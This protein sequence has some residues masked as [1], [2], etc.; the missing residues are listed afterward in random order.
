VPEPAD[1]LP[2]HRR[3]VVPRASELVDYL[4]G[5]GRRK[6]LFGSNHPAW[7]AAGELILFFDTY[8]DKAPGVPPAGL[9][10]AEVD[11]AD[12]LFISHA[13]WDHLYGA[14]IIA[15]G[16]GATLVGNY[17]SVRLMRA[18]GVPDAQI[19]VTAGG[20]TVDCGHGV[21]VRALPSQHSGLYAAGSPD[22][23]QDCLGDLGVSAQVRQ[24]RTQA[25]FG[26]AF[27][28]SDEDRAYF[29][30]ASRS[31]SSY[32]GGQLAYL[33][34]SPAGSLLVSSSAG[35]WRSIFEPL[36]PD[37]A[38]LG[39]TGRPVLDG[40]P[41]QGSLA[42]FLAEEAALLGRP[43]VIFCHYDPLLPPLFGAT[44]ITAAETR[45]KE[46]PGQGYRRLE[47]GAPTT[48]LPMRS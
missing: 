31:T 45:L 37:V 20:D 22:S 38:I 43:E 32:D 41:Y 47:Y 3:A 2:G 28:L 36:R 48:V 8:L 21:T 16:T 46:I 15:K 39:A 30:L 26:R 10:A 25:V 18:S 5:H 1:P 11:R 12:F 7:P 23:G 40:E 4:R 19:V 27:T 6:V 29:D 14:D 34:E 33:L 24:A 44:D 42:G 17:E 35:Y 9:R 13:H